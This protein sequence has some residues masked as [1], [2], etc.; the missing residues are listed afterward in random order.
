MRIAYL[1]TVGGIAGDM[2]LGAFVSAGVSLDD[3]IGELK[4]LNVGGFELIGR[5][6][7][8]NGIVAVHI[9]VVIHH[10][11]HH[12]RHLEEIISI[13]DGSSL[14]A[15]VKSRA[16]T[17]FR[18]LA[19]AEARV[20]NTTPDKVHFHE[21]GALDAIV[22]ITGT[23][24]CLER[25]GIEQVFSSPVKVGSGGVVMSEH[26]HIPVPSPATLE[27]LKG[28]PVLLTSVA[29]ELT[30][31]TGASIIK[32]LSAGVLTGDQL[33]IHSIGYGAGTKEFSEFPNVLRV[34]IGEVA[35]SREYDELDLIETNIDDMNPQLYPNLLEKLVASGAND[36]YLTPVIM[37]KG[38]PGMLLSVMA[39]TEMVDGIVDLLYSHTSTIGLRIHKVSRKKL[40]R[41][42]ILVETSFGPVRAKAVIRGGRE[43]IA[44]E[45]EECRRIAEQRGIPLIT[46]L[47]TLER[48]LSDAHTSR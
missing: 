29:H 17:M 20:H 46:V 33:T 10:E 35:S 4:K 27:I 1:D 5:H 37:K 36:A 38:R 23:A 15:L 30:T 41:R 48:E 31:P 45:F 11:G 7:T 19:E 39:R 44:A 12:H 43:Q 42:E 28:Y 24:I 22:D 14:S 8:R 16:G 21:V 2:T 9:E 18:I 26:G 40:P 32:G 6:M 13:I 25:L 47:H 34:V 3:L